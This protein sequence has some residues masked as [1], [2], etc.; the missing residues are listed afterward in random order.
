MR[1]NISRLLIIFGILAIMAAIGLFVYN[2]YD[3]KR[4]E[5]ASHDI[6]HEIDD[7]KKT[8][9]FKEDFYV[10]EDMPTPLH[11]LY[12][13]MDMPAVE[14]DG[15][16]YIATLKIPSIKLELPIM[17]DWDYSRLKI[18]P[19]RYKGSAYT[20]DLVIAGHNYASHFSKIKW[21]EPE[22]EVILEDMKGNVFKYTIA[23][24]EVID[25]ENVDEMTE[26]VTVDEEGNDI[27]EENNWDLTLFTCTTGGGSRFAARCVLDAEE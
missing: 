22:T 27:S 9:E 25:P 20:H 6:I 4:A 24:T 23:W 15:Y 16:R 12:P 2:V 8:E 3:S 1:K 7:A 26:K 11:E 14:I 13:M 5:K 10:P 19:C 18:S 21:L 17:E